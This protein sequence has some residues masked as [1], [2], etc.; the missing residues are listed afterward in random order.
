MQKNKF[1]IAVLIPLAEIVMSSPAF[2]EDYPNQ[3]LFL[4]EKTL[5][6]QAS[7]KHQ[8]A[9]LKQVTIEFLI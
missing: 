2:A 8:D 1:L 9:S 7:R 4:G 6:F 5:N 3:S